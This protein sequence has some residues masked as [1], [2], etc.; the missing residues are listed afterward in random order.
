[1]CRRDRKPFLMDRVFNEGGLSNPPTP[2]FCAGAGARGRDVAW[3]TWAA[4]GSAW[5]TRAGE[6]L[7]EVRACASCDMPYLF[8]RPGQPACARCVTAWLEAG[9]HAP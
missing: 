4:T 6:V 1:M 9:R 7:D 5:C 8:F 2:I 3:R